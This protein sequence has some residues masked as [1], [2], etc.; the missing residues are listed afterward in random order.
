MRPAFIAVLA[1]AP[2]PAARAAEQGLLSQPALHGNRLIFVSEDDL[3]SADLA[4]PEP[5]G[6]L[7]AWRLTSSPGAERNPSISPDGAR[8]AFTAEYDGNPDVYV[9]PINGGVPQRLTFH[10]AE[11]VALDWSSDGRDVL[12]RSGRAHPLGRDELFRV[13]AAGGLP[14]RFA[15]GEC[16]L[17]GLSPSGRRF[18]FTRWSNEGW[19]WKRYRGGLAPDVWVGDLD[20]GDFR[21]ITND[22][23]S[24]LFPMWIQG[25]VAFLSDRTGTANIHSITPE[26]G[27]ARQHTRFGPRPGAP[28]AVEGHDV[29]WPARDAARRG[30]RIV[31]CQ[32]GQL[33]LLDLT[34]DSIT[35]LPVRLASDR[36]AARRRFVDGLESVTE[37]ALSATGDQILLGARGEV[38]ALD[39]RGAGWTQATRSSGAREWGLC[40]LSDGRLALV[41][42]AGGE[43]QIA[44]LDV[45]GEIGLVTSDRA[46]WLFPPVA[47]PGATMLAFGDTAQRLHTVDL[48]T[49]ARRQVAESRGGGITDYRFS[50]D[51]HWLAFTNPT[52]DERSEVVIHSLRTGRSFSAGDGQ[53]SDREPRWD[54]AGRYLYLLSDRHVDPLLD[55]IGSGYVAVGSTVV[56]AL[57]LARHTPPPVAALAEP[58]GFDLEAWAESGTPSP[59]ADAAA[60]MVVD[61][62]DLAR[63]QHVLPIEPGRLERLEALPGGVTL[64][65]RPLRGLVAE[66]EE[67]EGDGLAERF[68][69]ADAALELHDLAAGEMRE[70]AR[71]VA[72]YACS[73]DGGTVAW[74]QQRGFAVHRLGG[75]EEGTRRAELNELPL[76]LDVADEWRHI[77]EEAWRLQR[78]FFWSPRMGGADWPAMREKY[79]ALLPLVGTRAELNDVIGQMLGELA[80]SHAYVFGGEPAREPQRVEVGLLGA[81][82]E[83]DG[84]VFRLARIL[85]SAPW[86]DEFA[87]P[88]DLAHLGI[89]PGTPLLAI[90]GVMLSAQRNPLALLQDRAGQPVRL[91]LGE[92]R[93]P[94]TVVVTPVADEAPLRYAAWVQA[95]RRFVEERSDGALG[96]VHVP[97]M[98]GRGLALFTHQFHGQSARRGLIVDVRGN[99]GGFVSQLI[100]ERLSRR[101]LGLFWSRHGVAA[102]YPRHGLH[103][104]LA[105]LVDEHSGSD[106][107]LFPSAFGA[108]GLGPVVGA[109]TWGGT[110]A[111]RGDKPFLDM[112]LSTQPEFAWWDRVRGWAIEN[113]GVIPDLEV[114]LTPADRAAGHDP[115]L[116]AAVG[117]LLQKLRDEPRDLPQAMPPPG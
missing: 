115:Q 31:F 68:G 16:S 64:L 35:R 40:P 42:D 100:L 49:L 72:A 73:A 84:R 13:P 58:A 67:A 81:D 76:A 112:G 87:A 44:V 96:Y 116:D 12:F 90:D 48:A 52:G 71:Q 61:T 5:D 38:V 7:L 117:L 51:G 107:D 18:A 94:R 4:R 113:Q 86:G 91:M 66:E 101:L 24:D 78:D 32:A 30:G 65:R 102:R 82:L 105:V 36:S 77:F 21:R 83:H 9:M 106:G 80:T 93:G 25:R 104:H 46:A 109:R 54:P 20:T 17:I 88:L 98:G 50:P 28:T 45:D 114:P 70:L 8:L 75:A 1:L 27:D 14:V 56:V 11:D 59:A 57:P 62:E 23:G 33:A 15:L 89:E 99:G 10:P 26:G 74:P 69:A 53:S 63:R 37:F 79:R 55:E 34:D 6:T 47:N 103:A 2:G 19:S 108:L 92:E 39:A 110:I 60:P 22:P 29:R 3:W 95:N 111:T 85:R 43:Q 41:T 97:D